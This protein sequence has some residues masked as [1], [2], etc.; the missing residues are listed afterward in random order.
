MKRKLLALGIPTYKR[1]DYVISSLKNSLSMRVYDEIIISCNSHEPLI[2]EFIAS[3]G[4][5]EEIIYNVQKENV[6]LS[7]NYS[8]IINLCSCEY[9]HII[10]DEDHIDV[11][12]LKN[13]YSF[14][15][16]NNNFSL[17]LVS[18]LEQSGLIYKDTSYQKSNKI[19]NIC[20]DSGH[21]GSSIIKVKNWD[22]ISR[23]HMID[24]CNRKG[25]VYPTV[26]AAILSYVKE[27]NLSYYPKPLIIMGKHHKSSEL[28]G[29]NTYGM[30]SRIYQLISLGLLVD[31]VNLKESFKVKFYLIYFFSSHAFQDS[32]EKFNEN[33][34][35]LCRKILKEDNLGAKSKQ[36]L[37]IALAFYY[38]LRLYRGLR[39]LISIVV[40]F[41]LRTK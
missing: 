23:Q 3:L 30:E 6:G 13:F 39:R 17:I 33:F 27:P 31:T 41:L 21:I 22:E 7:R 34:L 36:L 19:K 32:R 16:K 5:Q 4:N 20:S 15:H 29:H 2:N 10:S 18:I 14:L 9:L 8:D 28:S 1:P 11:T 40:K 26:A 12:N 35:L 25:S 37:F 38:Y 24:Y